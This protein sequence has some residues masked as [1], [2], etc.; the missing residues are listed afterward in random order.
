LVLCFEETR[1]PTDWEIQL[2]EFGARYAEVAL[3]RDR[4]HSAIRQSEEKYRALFESM[5]EGFC[6]CEML[7]DAQ[8][9]P[10]DYKFLET[11]PMLHL[12]TGL[13]GAVG[14]TMRELVP[15][16]E[17]EWFE[18]YGNVVRTSQPTRFEQYSP[19][20]NRWFDVNAFPVGE[21]QN[22]QFAVLFTNTTARKQVEQALSASE[23]QSR[24]I[25]ESITDAFFTVDRAWRFTY[26]N[27]QCEELLNGTNGKLLGQIIWEAF[28]GLIG[29]EFERAYYQSATEGIAASTTAFYPDHNRW[30]EVRSY[31]AADGITVYFRNITEQRESEATLRA[32]EQQ[33]RTIFNSTSRSM[34]LIDRQGRLVR[35]N[36]ASRELMDADLD[37]VI[38]QPFWESV[39]F[40]NTPK[41][42]AK[43]QRSIKRALAGESLRF[44][45]P[46]VR[47]NGEV[48]TFDMSF[49]PIRNE[50]DE[51]VFV[52]QE[53]T[54]ITARQKAT[55]AL[56]EKVKNAFATWPITLLSLPG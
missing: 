20:L 36:R 39:W 11:N 34:G 53:A 21:A 25:L 17:P 7:F 10:V 37:T 26:L 56:E 46:I 8:G 1:E 27:P 33:L 16:L 30:Y 24:N 35:S 18:I 15:D 54:D 55:D 29:T 42:S 31:P 49:Y 50:A 5:D 3:Q 38:G 14:K 45:L 6:I 43:V 13:E 52:V 40:Q 48:S 47:P 41:A 9:Q 22:N 2:T 12:L 28:P 23:A 4:T 32:S 44:D 51:V 19:A